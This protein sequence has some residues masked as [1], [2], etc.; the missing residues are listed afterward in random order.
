MTRDLARLGGLGLM[1]VA[2]AMVTLDGRLAL[3]FSIS[4]VIAQDSKTSE[5]QESSATASENSSTTVSEEEYAIYSSLIKEFYIKPDIHL[6]VVEDRTFRYDRSR[7]E[8][9]EPWN[10]KVKGITVEPSTVSDFQEKNLRHCELKRESFKLPV[11]TQLTTDADLRV[12]FRQHWGQV[13][14]VNYYNRYPD[15]SG[16]IRVS[17]VG[18]NTAHTQGMLYI[19]S[20]C[21]PECGDIHFLLL[22]KT[23]STWVI[24]KQIRKINLG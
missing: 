18:F 17:R 1:I 24:K 14:W 13:E 8:D 4:A 16:L 5:G 19:G 6:I 3:T 7:D 23:G 15:S 10:S 21:G 12:I 22:E 11:K 2:M 20:L 9:D